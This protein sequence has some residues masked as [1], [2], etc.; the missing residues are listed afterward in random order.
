MSS[1]GLADFLARKRVFYQTNEPPIMTNEAFQGYCGGLDMEQKR[2]NK[3]LTG[4][5]KVVVHLA[6]QAPPS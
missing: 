4:P 5:S 2:T 6:L 3:A 1:T